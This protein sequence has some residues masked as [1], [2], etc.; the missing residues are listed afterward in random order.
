MFSRWGSQSFKLK[1]VV[2]SVLTR[3]MSSSQTKAALKPFYFAVHP[4][5]FGEYPKQKKINEDSLKRLNSYIDNL[6][7]KSPV[8]PTHLIFYLKNENIETSIHT[9]ES[10]KKVRVSLF[11]RDLHFTI[12]QILKSCGMLEDLVALNEK[13]SATPP[14]VFAHPYSGPVYW[15]D[16]Y[17]Q[18]KTSPDLAHIRRVT[19]FTLRDFVNKNSESAMARLESSRITRKENEQL[20]EKICKEFN[21]NKLSVACG[22]SCSS[23]QAALKN[24]SEFCLTRRHEMKN[25]QG[26]NVIFSDWT[27]VDPHGNVM[28]SV[29]DVP[30]FWLELFGSI[31]DYDVLLHQLPTWTGRASQLLGDLQIVHGA[32]C[33]SVSVTEYLNHLHRVVMA[34]RHTATSKGR[35]LL[36]PGEFKGFEAAILSPVNSLSLSISGQFRIPSSASADMIRDFLRKHKTDSLNLQKEHARN[37]V[38]EEAIIK[39]CQEKLKLEHLSKDSTVSPA[40]MIDCC[41]RLINTAPE[42]LFNNRLIISKFYNVTEDGDINIPWNWK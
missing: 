23:Y 5:L 20:A 26:R 19:E 17:H 33:P 15:S 22:W 28:L 14:A 13:V 36:Y 10:L 38:N 6:Q 12:S 34:V 25:V 30:E 41:M 18:F 8:N 21:L 29:Q 3:F 35:Q 4:D 24:F 40:Q 31:C 27:G 7:A 42:K 16:I 2:S 1:P 39:S 9:S 11:S 37:G 32:D